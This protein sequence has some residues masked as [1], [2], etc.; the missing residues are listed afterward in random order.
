ME[1]L[2]DLLVSDESPA[3]V[4]DKIKDILYSKSAEKI[5]NVRP[6][7]ASSLFDDGEVEDSE[8]TTDETDTEVEANADTE[9]EDQPAEPT[10][11]LF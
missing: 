4:S 1:E 3:Q 8:E 10:A 6:D 2:M 11:K 5:K 7:V 9:V